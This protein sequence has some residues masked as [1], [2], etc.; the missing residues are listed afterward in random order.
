M[1][2]IVRPGGTVAAWGYKDF[3]FPWRMEASRLVGEYTYGE[4]T[5]G[6]YWVQPGRSR[7]QGRLRSVDPPGEG[8]EEVERWEYE[9]VFED[10]VE[11]GELGYEQRVKEDFGMSGRLVKVGEPLMRFEMA[12]GKVELYTRTWSAVHA[13][14]EAHPGRVSRGEG[15]EGDI[16][17]E[18]FDRL[19]EVV[20]EWAGEGWRDKVVDIE[21]GHGVV[22]ARR[23]GGGFSY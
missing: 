1:A 13:W 22:C 3:A 5:L 9:T 12:L 18:L 10:G 6:P 11:L 21:L 2:R 19:R 20:P 8:W 15:G 17:D 16:V 14:K 23:K 7:V 4:G